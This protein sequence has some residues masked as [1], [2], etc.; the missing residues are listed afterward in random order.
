M[1]T[2]INNTPKTDKCVKD[3]K[4]LRFL[5][6]DSWNGVNKITW[7]NP[8]VHLC[9]IL[10]RERDKLRM[11]LNAEIKA[12]EETTA[13]WSCDNMEVTFLQCDLNQARREINELLKKL[14]VNQLNEYKN[15][16]TANS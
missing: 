10:E 1:N 2:E 6:E 7:E 9:R 15:R 5:Q 4:H 8:I 12:H 11:E 14:S 3:N 13:K 16:R